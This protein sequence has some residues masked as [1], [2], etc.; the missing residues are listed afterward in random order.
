LSQNEVAGV[1]SPL[2]LLRD[3]PRVFVA[4]VIAVVLGITFHEFSHAAV[5]TLQGDQTAR[6]QGRLTLNPIAHLDPLGS[7]A[8]ILAGFGWGRPVPFNPMRLRSRRVGAALVGLAGPAAN[9]VLALAAA[10]GVRVLFSTGTGAFEVN[11]SLILLDM[12]VTLNVVLGV[13]N[14]LPIPPLDGSRLLSIF[15]PPSR[16]NIVYFLDRYGIFLLLG[17]LILAPN[18]LTP[19]FRSI[20]RAL[21]GLVGL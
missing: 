18:L 6:S 5:A 16:Q 10:I 20:T 9:F 11:F 17:L 14:L 13:F 2:F 7:I 12:L 19:L 15:L 8:L 3:D 4:F 1:G 21:Y